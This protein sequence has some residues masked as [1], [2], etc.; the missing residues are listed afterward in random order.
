MCRASLKI[1]GYAVSRISSVSGID[2]AS[3]SID[4]AI[5][6]YVE[7]VKAGTFPAKEHGYD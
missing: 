2:G 5:R 6:A 1:Y 4:G 3:T 7:A